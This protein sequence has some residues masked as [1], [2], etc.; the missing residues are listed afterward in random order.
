M[1]EVPKGESPPLLD[2]IEELDD[3]AAPAAFYSNNPEYLGRVVWED[4]KPLEELIDELNVALQFVGE[5][6]EGFDFRRFYDEWQFVYQ[7]VEKIGK[8]PVVKLKIQKS[9]PKQRGDGIHYGP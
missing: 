7:I 5:E 9:M 2:M 6:V 4:F 8:L 1:L 3:F